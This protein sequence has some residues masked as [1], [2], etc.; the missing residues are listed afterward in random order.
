MKEKL[1]R[2]VCSSMEHHLVLT[3]DNDVLYVSVFLSEHNLLGRIKTALK[4][5]FGYK[6][7]FGHWEEIVL[8]GDKVSELYQFLNE[9]SKDKFEDENILG[10]INFRPGGADKLIQILASQEE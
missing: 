6:C 3:Y 5:I 9:Y 8:D 7:K 10:K 1:F 2:C 4:Y